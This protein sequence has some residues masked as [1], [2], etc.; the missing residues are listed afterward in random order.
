MVGLRFVTKNRRAEP[1]LVRF[2]GTIDTVRVI[3][4][5]VLV[6]RPGSEILCLGM[7]EDEGTN[8]GG[9]VHHERILDQRKRVIQTLVN[10]ES[11]PQG[12][13]LTVIGLRRVA[14]C[15]ANA[16]EGRLEHVIEGQL[17]I[18]TESPIFL[19]HNLVD[20]FSKRFCESICHSIEH[21][22]LVDL[23][24]V[25]KLLALGVHLETGGA[26]EHAEVVFRDPLG[27]NEIGLAFCFFCAM[28]SRNRK[29]NMLRGSRLWGG[30]GGLD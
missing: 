19:A 27:R 8:G 3:H 25:V 11:I 7:G 16:L 17:F 5:L 30:E 4:N 21:D 6:D 24:G 20:I 18:R 2:D 10:F 23:A 26:R 29:K 13:L 22:D 1:P 14:G 9:R 15:G 28:K 12:A